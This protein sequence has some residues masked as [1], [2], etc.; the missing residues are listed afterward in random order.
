MRTETVIRFMRIMPILNFVAAIALC[1][2]M[3]APNVNIPMLLIGVILNLFC[4]W[5]GLMPDNYLSNKFGSLTM[6]LG[7]W[8]IGGRETPA[9]ADAEKRAMDWAR[10]SGDAYAK[11]ASALSL[12]DEAIRERDEYRQTAINGG[13]AI[14]NL[15]ALNRELDE[16]LYLFEDMKICNAAFQ[17]G[18]QWIAKKHQDLQKRHDK[19]KSQLKL[20]RKAK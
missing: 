11:C 13:K 9:L 19:L 8:L 16:K 3:F 17:D 5:W 10:K 20:K 14:D 7:L 15:L 12:K 6:S 4:G 1:V 2:A 18:Y